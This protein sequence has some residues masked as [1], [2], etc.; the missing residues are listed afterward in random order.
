MKK[1]KNGYK[2]ERLAWLN[3][4]ELQYSLTGIREV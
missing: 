4:N 3:R 2:V 1:E